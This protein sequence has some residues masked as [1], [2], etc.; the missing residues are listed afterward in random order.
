MD[1]LQ[2]C[3]VIRTVFVYVRLKTLLFRV[4]LNCEMLRNGKNNEKGGRSISGL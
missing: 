4:T 1:T 3:A 2:F